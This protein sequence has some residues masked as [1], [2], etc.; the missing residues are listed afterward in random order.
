MWKSDPGLD[1]VMR[2][3]SAVDAL[4]DKLVSE[5]SVAHNSL[6]QA[7]RY[8]LLAPGK[9]IRPLLAISTGKMLG[10]SLEAL[11][12]PA[13]AL[14]MIHTY[15]LIHDDLPA[16][17]DDDFRRGKPSL[18][19]AFG[20]GNAILVGDYLLTYAFEVLSLAPLLTDQQRLQL[21][22]LLAQASGGDGMIGGQI[23]DLA[24]AGHSLE[25]VNAKKTG[26]LICAAVQFGGVVAKANSEVF[27]SLTLLGQKIGLLFQVCDD[28][29]DEERSSDLNQALQ[30]AHTLYKDS[31]TLLH[32]IP[33]D[34]TDLKTLFKSIIKQIEPQATFN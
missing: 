18:H 19:K 2:D 32:R 1:D 17:D 31:L 21:I 7:A 10:S 23:M 4:L 24:K 33:G 5:S 34:P 14:E 27:S 22:T 15:S 6:Y 16:M 12:H 9:R 20:E 11:L 28:I 26:A 13:C 8:S 3:L 25:E 29:L 30:E